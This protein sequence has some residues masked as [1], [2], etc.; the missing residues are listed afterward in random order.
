MKARLSLDLTSSKADGSTSTVQP[1]VKATV[2][3]AQQARRR[4][5]AF[6]SSLVKR[7]ALLGSPGTKKSFAE[8]QERKLRKGVCLFC[9]LLRLIVCLLTEKVKGSTVIEEIEQLKKEEGEMKEKIVAK[10]EKVRDK[11]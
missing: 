1:L 3:G 5:F 7:N 9:V 4:L 6:S 10:I 2:L 11:G 8:K